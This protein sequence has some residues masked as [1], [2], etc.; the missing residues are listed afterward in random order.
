MY[1][2]ITYRHKHVEES[3]GG[4]RRTTSETRI[5]DQSKIRKSQVREAEEDMS[6]RESEKKIEEKKS[7]EREKK[8]KTDKEKEQIKRAAKK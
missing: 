7:K 4:R 8:K 6:K 1:Y 5:H 2:V 3:H